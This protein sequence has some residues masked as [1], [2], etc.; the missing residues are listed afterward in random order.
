MTDKEFKRLNRAQLI[1]IIYQLQVKLD[2]LSEE[3][4]LEEELLSDFS[5]EEEELF[6]ALLSEEVS[7]LSLSEDSETEELSLLLGVISIICELLSEERFPRTASF[8]IISGSSL[9]EQAA[10]LKTMIAERKM[11]IIFFILFPPFSYIIND[12]N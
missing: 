10:M 2:E 1:E 11:Q 5:E 12:I 4:A 3:T 6:S 9:A 8:S 7:E